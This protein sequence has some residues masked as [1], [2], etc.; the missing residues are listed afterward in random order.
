[1]FKRKLK[2]LNFCDW[3]KVDGNDKQ[4]IKKLVLW[5]ENQK[6]RQ[7]KLDDRKDLNNIASAD[8][9]LYFEK[10]LKDVGCPEF[11]TQLSK[12]EWL[13]GLAVKLE[14]EDNHEKYKSVE[15]SRTKVKNI[16]DSIVSTTNPL[17]NLDFQ[18]NDFKDGINTLAKL[19]SI[20]Q[21]PN[22]LITLEA[23][24]QFICKRLNHAAVQNPN[25]VIVKGIPYPIM[26]TSVGFNMVDPVLNNAA[27]IL[28][29]L[30]I[31]DLR[32]LQTK[33]NEAIVNVQNITANP[34]TNTKLGK[35][36]IGKN[37][38]YK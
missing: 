13:I 38:N 6:I 1:M 18:S 31:Q 4:H 19:L 26:E 5:L 16:I 15:S 20:P 14:F 24:S 23:C 28:S 12:I 29:I 34:K 8:W 10:Y 17:D 35:V 3:D 25:S 33:I 37:L 7:Y 36:G 22:H 30:Y 27:K 2:A 21:H 9:Q 11:E 32:D